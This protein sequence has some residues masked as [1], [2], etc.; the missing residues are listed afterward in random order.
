[1]LSVTV[2]IQTVS[3]MNRR[4]HWAKRHRRA[5]DQKDLVTLML[6]TAKFDRKRLV[7]PFVVKMTRLAPGAIKDSDNLAAATK[8]A[9]DAI[10]AFLGV[11]DADL[12]GTGQVRWI[13]AQERGKAYGLRIEIESQGCQGAE[14]PVI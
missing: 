12:L 6:R 10:A 1:M 5:R 3:E 2:P 8:A 13:V 9:R 11:D 7:A 14:S 4:D